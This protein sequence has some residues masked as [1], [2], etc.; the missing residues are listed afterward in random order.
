MYIRLV[1]DFG[2]QI[3]S[4][5]GQIEKYFFATTVDHCSMK[6]FLISSTYVYVFKDLNCCFVCCLNFYQSIYCLTTW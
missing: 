2:C 4:I 1:S 5:S 6:R 3:L